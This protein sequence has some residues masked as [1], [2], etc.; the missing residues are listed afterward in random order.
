MPCASRTRRSVQ[1]PIIS[2]VDHTNNFLSEYAAFVGVPSYDVTTG[3]PAMFC[4]TTNDRACK[5]YAN[6]L[7][8]ANEIGDTGVPIQ[9]LRAGDL[10][11][12]RVLVLAPV[13]A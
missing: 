9:P 10:Q 7:Y 4:G 11:Q 2:Y 13:P 5:D 1:F 3:G 12:L 6:Q 8:W